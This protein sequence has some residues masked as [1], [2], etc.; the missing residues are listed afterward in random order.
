MV[1]NCRLIPAI[2]CGCGHDT[3]F[4]VADRWNVVC[5]CVSITAMSLPT[6]ITLVML[7]YHRYS[8]LVFGSP[9]LATE[10]LA[11]NCMYS[12]PL[13]FS[14]MNNVTEST[15]TRLVLPEHKDIC[16]S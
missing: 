10:H 9:V 2:P 4:E 5:H 11:M 7:H 3:R 12:M 14:L 1:L 8:G 16:V 15:Y 13:K 6:H